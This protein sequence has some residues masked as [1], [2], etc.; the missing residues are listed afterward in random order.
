MVESSIRAK[1]LQDLGVERLGG[2]E[3]V[4][5]RLL[6]HDSVPLTL[7]LVDEARGS[8]TGYRDAE[9]ERACRRGEHRFKIPDGS[10]WGDVKAASTSI[11]EVLTKA[12]RAVGRLTSAM[13]LLRQRIRLL[14]VMSMT[15]YAIFCANGIKR[16]VAARNSS[17]AS[18]CTG[19]AVC[20]N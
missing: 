19:N 17:L 11:G 6:D 3:V 18:M 20:C 10:R 7:F 2:S 14:I 8:E 1:R 9:Y 13:A 4:A 15:E 16:Q 5:E 12:M